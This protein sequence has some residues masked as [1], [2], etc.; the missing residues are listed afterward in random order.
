VYCCGARR[1]QRVE[2]ELSGLARGA[3]NYTL[4]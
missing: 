4:C 2:R 3:S 1:G